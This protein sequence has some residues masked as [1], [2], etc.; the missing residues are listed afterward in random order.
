MRRKIFIVI[1][2]LLLCIPILAVSVSAM[3]FNFDDYLVSATF[4]GSSYS[5]RYK[6]PTTSTGKFLLVS[7]S[8]QLTFTGYSFGFNVGLNGL[9][10]DD[11]LTMAYYPFGDSNYFTLGSDG[12]NGVRLRSGGLKWDQ[13]NRTSGLS[14]VIGSEKVR[15]FFYDKFYNQ[16]S[17]WEGDPDI[18]TLSV[19]GKAVYFNIQY[20]TK[21]LITAE[22][23]SCTMDYITLTN[24]V[25]SDAR[26]EEGMLGPAGEYIPPSNGSSIGDLDQA[27]NDLLGGLGS[28]KDSIVDIASTAISKLSSLV[29][30]F[31][32][33]SEL[34]RR[35]F[36]ANSW[37]MSI[38]YV[39]LTVG[40]FALLVNVSASFV[41]GKKS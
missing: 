38:F 10:V 14:V 3:T 25:S 1:C 16:L 19:P 2:S 23:V 40:I 5:Y 37:S 8:K 22:T 29:T 7:G 31:G 24:I 27:E 32:F 12:T 28:V 41:G 26:T 34:I 35:F 21:F 30:S 18:D 11:Y 20:S 6:I 33:V 36:L 4:D 39:S 9:N 13:T 17:I 15:I